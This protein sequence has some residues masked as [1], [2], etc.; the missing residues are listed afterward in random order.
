MNALVDIIFSGLFQG[1]L[2]A[3]MAVGLA[4][5]WTTSGVFN[6]AH[7]VLIMLGAYLCWQLAD[8]AGFGLPLYLSLPVTMIAVGLLGWGLQALVV[9]PF[10]G[11]SDIVLIVVIMTL[12]SGSFLENMTLEVWGPR[13][14]QLPPLL[15]GTSSF[16]GFTASMNQ[17]AI[18]VATPVILLGVWL[19]LHRTRL[20]LS[21]RAVAQ[22]NDASRLVGLKPGFLFGVSFALAAALAALAG[23]FLGSFKF[24]SP[25]MGTE[26]LTK[27]LIVVIFGGIGSING[28]ILAAYIIGLI[29]AASTYYLG[30]YWTPTLLFFILIAT[31]MIRPEGLLAVKKRGLS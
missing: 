21:L 11:H 24:M 10:I 16:M 3:I 9:R 31:L 1:S 22:N 28:P 8:E 7:G 27:A 25:G 18:I 26:P 23:I 12:A 13:P 30:L 29:E 6:F 4:L 2:Y 17:L 20:G 15:P 5:V 19:L 14:K